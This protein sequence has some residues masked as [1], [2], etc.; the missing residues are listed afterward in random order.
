M[1]LAGK[2]VTFDTGGISLKP[3]LRM[4]MMKMD[5]SGGAAVLG[6]METIGRLGLG[7]RVIGLVGATENMPS[8]C[9]LYTS[10]CV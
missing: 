8:G 10:R 3:G 6:A 2:A 1:V 7:R 4:G 9:L 5:M